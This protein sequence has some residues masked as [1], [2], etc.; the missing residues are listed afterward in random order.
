MERLQ[1]QFE[2][3]V[4]QMRQLPYQVDSATKLRLYGLHQQARF[5]NNSRTVPA[6]WQTI[7]FSKYGAWQDVKGLSAEQAM[8]HYIELAEAIGRSQ[9]C[10]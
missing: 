3:A 2:R 7:E 8:R 4:M 6:P 10:H 9:V 5:G 1:Q